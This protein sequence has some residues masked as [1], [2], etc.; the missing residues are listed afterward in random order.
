MSAFTDAPAQ[1]R[2]ICDSRIDNRAELAS[3]L[4]I[5]APALTEMSDAALILRAYQRWGMDCPNRLIGDFAFAIWDGRHR[6]LFCARDPFG[7]KPLYY[8]WD[9]H[10]FLWASDIQALLG[11]PGVARRADDAMVM[12]YLLWE[13]PDPEATFFDGIKQLQPAHALW[14]EQGR[15]RRFRYWNP[16]ACTTNTRARAEDWLARFRDEFCE[17]VHC[18]LQAPSPIGLMLSGGIDSV[19]VAATAADQCHHRRASAATLSVFTVLY[20]DVHQHDRAAIE[21][22]IQR[23][24][25]RARVISPAIP[26]P[27]N[28]HLADAPGD[29]FIVHPDALQAI[30]DEGCRV[31]LTGVGADELLGSSELGILKGLL[32]RGRLMGLAR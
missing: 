1:L 21:R 25:L 15:L 26:P 5:S 2:I 22:L 6:R 3:A 9:G 28:S 16:A 31:V 7:V 18:R 14:V 10:R 23:Y 29:A 11:V 24:H 32:R 4:R 20:A 12:A 8:R 30:A 13:F 17:A 19:L 27:A